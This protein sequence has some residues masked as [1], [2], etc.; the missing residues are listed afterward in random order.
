[1]TDN[2]R[3]EWRDASELADNPRNW[4]KPL[5]LVSVIW[6]NGGNNTNG[7]LG[8]LTRIKKN[9]SGIKRHIKT[10]SGNTGDITEKQIGKSLLNV[11]GYIEPNFLNGPKPLA[12]NFGR[13]IRSNSNKPMRTL[14]LLRLL[15][16]A[17]IVYAVG[18]K[19]FVSL[20]LTISIT[21]A[22]AI[23]SRVKIRDTEFTHGL[24]KKV[25]LKDSFKF[26]VGIVIVLR[27]I[28]SMSGFIRKPLLLVGINLPFSIERQFTGETAIKL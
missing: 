14:K 11:L 1:M 23:E 26:F 22:T 8:W 25:I 16:L 21:M 17:G 4:R 13:T 3:L 2:L 24:K 28:K 19:R 7:G 12:E 10:N 15:L 20:P 6:Y 18:K 9:G 27:H 5:D